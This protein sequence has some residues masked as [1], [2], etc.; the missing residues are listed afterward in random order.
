MFYTYLFLHCVKLLGLR[1]FLLPKFLLEVDENKRLKRTFRFNNSGS[2][3]DKPKIAP[4]ATD[5]RR[6]G[7][8]YGDQ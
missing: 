1:R 3:A 2:F 6:C 7:V 4:E 5:V 8:I